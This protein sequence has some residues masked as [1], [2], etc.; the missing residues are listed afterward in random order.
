MK[1]IFYTLLSLVVIINTSCNKTL[2]EQPYS[3]VSSDELYNTDEGAKAAII[4]CHGT[5]ADFA[6][7]GAGYPSLINI[8]SGGFYT[9]QGP[10]Q[11]LNTLTFGPSTLFLTG[12]SPW[13]QFYQAIGVANDIIDKLPKGKASDSVKTQVLGEAYFMRGMLYFNLVRMFGG[14]PLRTK[15]AS[16]DDIHLPR[17]NKDSVY[18]LIISDF[19]KAKVMMPLPAQQIKGRPNRYAANALLGK[20]YI[21]RAGNDNTSPFWQKAK[22]EL[23]V[24][25]NSNAYSLEKSSTKLF[26]IN[27]E[28]CVESI[29]EVQYTITGAQNSQ[30]T[31][32]YC[33]NNS[34][35]T[36][37]A[38]NGPFGR[39]RCNKEIY[40]RHKA[41]YATDPRI[42]AN[43]IYGS[44]T[45]NGS[46]VTT[47]VYPAN[48]NGEGFPY[49]KMY[50]DPNY[51]ATRS[52]RNFI[53]LRYADVLL[54]L[55]ECENE[56]NGPANAYQYVNKV[57]TRARDKNGDGT[58]IATTPASWSGM[59]QN[60]FRDR[61]MLERRFELIGECHL[62]Y[63]VRRRGEAE[64]FKLL[65][66]HNTNPNFNPS[67]DVTY[68]LASRLMLFPIPA[69]EINANTMISPA[70]QNPGY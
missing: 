58:V 17:A 6:G 44:Y 55:A 9:T 52:N 59:T 47:K 15:P 38:Q 31:N 63:D 40:D 62:W 2:Q 66:E 12:N 50:V 33:P 27:N 41:T 65:T 8:A 14:V 22:D 25:Y 68:P 69:T 46:T 29:Y 56:L 54:M 49:L 7:F 5:A 43:Y 57:L 24:V 4:G 28:N 42:D 19:D 35:Y 23:M 32:Y 21:T 26:D 36:P 60:D 20:V 13:D 3:F 45:K 10:A 64:L 70:D 34:T 51:V 18:S 61:I 53:Y 11:D 37:L 16:Q 30:F 48:K 67:F 1:K 39:N